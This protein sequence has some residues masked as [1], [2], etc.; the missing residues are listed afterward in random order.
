MRPVKENETINF[1]CFYDFMPLH[2]YGD[3]ARGSQEGVG[4][5]GALGGMR[6]FKSRSFNTSSNVNSQGFLLDLMKAPNVTESRKL[7]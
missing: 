5:C 6:K 2:G 4:W 3:G 1:L 7:L